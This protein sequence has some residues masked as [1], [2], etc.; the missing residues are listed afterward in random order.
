MISEKS[1]TPSEMAL[2]IAVLS[3]QLV[4][5]KLAFSMFTPVNIS[6][7]LATRTALTGNFEYGTY[8]F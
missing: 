7:V 3:A 2:K 8:A 4:K 5:P 1:F 6:P